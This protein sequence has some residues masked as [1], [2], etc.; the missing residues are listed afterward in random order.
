MLKT[1]LAAPASFPLAQ[2]FVQGS[3]VNQFT[4]SRVDEKSTLFHDSKS[5]SVDEMPGL[6]SYGQVKRDEVCLL[7]QIFQRNIFNSPG[8]RKSLIRIGIIGNEPHSKPC[9]TA[10]HTLS[11]LPQPNHAQR[12]A[13]QFRTYK[14]LP[15]AGFDRG[16]ALRN[17]SGQGQEKGHRHV[18]NRVGDS[19]SRDRHRNASIPCRCE[20]NVL[21]ADPMLGDH[22]QMRRRRQHPL[23]DSFST[24]NE[25]IRFRNPCQKLFFSWSSIE[26]V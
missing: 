6:R 26:L 16:V 18:G 10:A 5:V 22:F 19:T 4:T 15:R 13:A 20:I 7:Q 24:G 23:C 21:V 14:A 9:S 11:N 25:D 12:F 1:S 17:L 8:S 3:L 2:G